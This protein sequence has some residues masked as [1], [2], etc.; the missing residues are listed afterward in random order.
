MLTEKSSNAETKTESYTPTELVDL[1]INLDETASISF[2]IEA[3]FDERDRSY[4]RQ[5]FWP[6]ICATTQRLEISRQCLEVID[7]RPD[8]T[9]LQITAPC[10]P[11][12]REY[13]GGSTSFHFNRIDRRDHSML[14][15]WRVGTE[16]I[17]LSII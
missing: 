4:I 12:T 10:L 7:D 16:P 9:V 5:H 8:H 1:I 13:S 15:T 2:N 17:A 3:S 6:F 11:L 14:T